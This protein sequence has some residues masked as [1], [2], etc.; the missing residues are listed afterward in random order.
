MSPPLVPTPH[1]LVHL[2]LC[3]LG[4]SGQAF[5]ETDPGEADR[6]SIVSNMTIGRYGRPVRVMAFNALDG[7]CRDVSAEIAGELLRAI[8]V[9]GLPEG[10]QAF[11]Q[12]QT[13]REAEDS[14]GTKL[15]SQ[16]SDC[17]GCPAP[18]F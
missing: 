8:E 6:F 11:V 3:D 7:T 16:R 18:N 14:D 10:T 5:V 2:V 9:D 17:A 15:P 1:Q 12:D 4:P 13:Q